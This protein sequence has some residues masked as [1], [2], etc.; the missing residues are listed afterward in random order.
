MKLKK[1]QSSWLSFAFHKHIG[2]F[3]PSSMSFMEWMDNF[4]L[5]FSPTFIYRHP[6]MEW[7]NI[8]FSTSLLG[9]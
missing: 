6:F 8:Y 5:I 2:Y 7:M 3:T 1:G 9:E 4:I